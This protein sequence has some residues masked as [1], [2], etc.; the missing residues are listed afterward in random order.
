[1]PAAPG[2]ICGDWRHDRVIGMDRLRVASLQYFIRPV[3]R[4]ET[5]RDQVVALADTAADYD[6]R[7]LVFPE[8]FTV[9]LLTLGDLRLP[10]PQQVRAL[11]RH[12]PAYIELMSGLAR[13]HGIYLV[14]G[15]IP[16][17]DE[18]TGE[19]HNESFFFGPTGEYGVQGKL[20]MT[21]FE[22]EE[23]RVSPRSTLRI[24]N[25]EFGRTA[26]AICY[27]VEFPEI[28]RAAALAGV[29]IL[30]VPSCTDDRH[31]F[32]RVRYCAQARA[33]EN[34]MYVIVS[35]TVGSLPMAPAVSLNYGQ[36]AILTP[37]DFPFSRDGVLAEGQPNQEMMV[38]GE[39]NLQTILE[40][41][42]AG[43]VIPLHDSQRRQRVSITTEETTL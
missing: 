4:F 9:Q 32:L 10:M 22:S 30:I 24:F 34:Q 35:H 25:T 36:A 43:T 27:D 15:T 38:I 28:A 13:R 7:L 23:W 8:Y 2:W 11:S 31:G 20:H 16:V 41:R 29:H 5:F 14:G 3:D 37:S 40:A 33:I 19:L 39:L 42:T 18:T 1:M 26:I 6:C 12:V 21:R 17:Q